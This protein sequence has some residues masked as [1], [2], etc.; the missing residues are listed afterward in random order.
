MDH[1]VY[2]VSSF[3]AITNSVRSVLPGCKVIHGQ[4]MGYC[5][6]GELMFVEGEAR[7]EDDGG[8]FNILFLDKLNQPYD[9]S[10]P[11]LSTMFE[12]SSSI[13]QYSLQ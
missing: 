3:F 9:L 7:G 2:V 4:R 6:E 12:D 1:C 10:V 8:D 13:G 11:D 5:S